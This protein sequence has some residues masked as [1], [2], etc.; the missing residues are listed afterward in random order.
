MVGSG[1]AGGWRRRL[2][3]AAGVVGAFVVTAQPSAVAGGS[4]AP[5][6]A[7]QAAPVVPAT[8]VTVW[9]HRWSGELSYAF[10]RINYGKLFNRA[11][12]G[13]WAPELPTY[14]AGATFVM[15]FRTRVV[16]SE[17]SPIDWSEGAFDPICQNYDMNYLDWVL[18]GDNQDGYEIRSGLTDEYCMTVEP[19]GGG[20]AVDGSPVTLTRCQG[21]VAQRWIVQ[22]DSH[23]NV[24]LTSM[25]SPDGERLVLDAPFGEPAANGG[26]LH[27]WSYH[28]GDNQRWDYTKWSYVGEEYSGYGVGFPDDVPLVDE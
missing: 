11:V 1:P 27:V 5:L 3:A 18:T 16:Y 7:R 20:R 2:L 14:Q 22:R 6:A 13:C 23:G 19:V 25:A 26:H 21:R 10:Y 28:G 9:E 24:I 12:D 17:T 8:Q 15:P 4:P